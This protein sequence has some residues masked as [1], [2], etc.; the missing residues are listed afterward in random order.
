MTD[1]EPLPFLRDPAFRQ[2][3]QDVR[4]TDNRTNWLYI[5]RSWLFLLAVLTAS[6]VGLEWVR[7]SGI[8]W[9]WAIPII[10][11]SGLLVGAEP[12]HLGLLSHDSSPTTLFPTSL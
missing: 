8:G 2:F 12:H 3:L 4:Q 10:I 9:A 6:V 1:D 11:F 7:E 5:A